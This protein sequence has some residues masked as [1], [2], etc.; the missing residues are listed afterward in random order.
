[1]ALYDDDGMGTSPKGLPI[2]Y[3]QSPMVLLNG[4]TTQDADPVSAKLDA[5]TYWIAIVV[6]SNTTVSAAMDMA[7]PG[8]QLDQ[9]FDDPY[10]D[11][12]GKV[13]IDASGND[14]AMY[15]TVMDTN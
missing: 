6:D 13:G 7:E 10:P 4:N 11:L 8:E 14:L 1:M 9:N 12:T 5:G 2:A 3:V 15:V